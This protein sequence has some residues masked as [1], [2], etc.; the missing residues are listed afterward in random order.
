MYV[1]ADQIGQQSPL[2]SPAVPVCDIHPSSRQQDRATRA[3]IREALAPDMPGACQQ[4]P[5]GHSS[6]L[7]PLR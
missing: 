6:P 5:P 7:S 4:G 2:W 1:H 3:T